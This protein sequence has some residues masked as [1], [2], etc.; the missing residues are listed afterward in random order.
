VPKLSPITD[1]ERDELRVLFL[2]AP[3]GMW[4]VLVTSRCAG[5]VV[6]DADNGSRSSIGASFYGEDAAR[7]TAAARNALPRLFA[8]IDDPRARTRGVPVV[9]VVR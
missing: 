3:A 7:L 9:G 1:D 4:A 5:P 2:A 6:A 8:A